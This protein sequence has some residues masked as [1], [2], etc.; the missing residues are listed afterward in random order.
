VFGLAVS[1]GPLPDPAESKLH[2][3]SPVAGRIP[4]QYV[5]LEKFLLSRLMQEADARIFTF[6]GIPMTAQIL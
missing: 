5:G 4:Q 6:A 3:I 1:Q 2:M